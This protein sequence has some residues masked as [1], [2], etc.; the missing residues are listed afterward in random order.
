[1]F[2]NIGGKL[3]SL[4]RLILLVGLVLSIIV[5]IGIWITGGGL[6]GRGGGFTTFIFGL[7]AGALGALGSWGG[8]LVTFGFG[9]LIEDTQAIRQ[10]IEDVQYSADALRRMT[11]ERRRGT[12]Q[13]PRPEE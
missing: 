7:L 13:K 4:A 12:A 1:M 3:K 11:E 8:S 2:D 10:N 6:A 5:M 9:Q